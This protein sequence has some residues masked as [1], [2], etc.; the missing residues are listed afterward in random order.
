[1]G[2][3]PGIVGSALPFRPTGTDIEFRIGRPDTGRQPLALGLLLI[4]MKVSLAFF[5]IL[6]LLP[7]AMAAQAALAL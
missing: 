3:S 5:A 7:A 2:R 6:V 1:M 4:G